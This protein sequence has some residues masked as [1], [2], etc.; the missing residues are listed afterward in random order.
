ME[1]SRARTIGR[2]YLFTH[3]ENASHGFAV[4]PPDAP[5]TLVVFSDFE[6]PFCRRFALVVDS[7]KLV[8]P[9]VRIVERNFPLEDIHHAAFDA[10]RAA[11]CARDVLSYQAVRRLLF[12]RQPLVEGRQ[13]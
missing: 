8:H 13:W 12:S 6:C 1:G 5:V 11:E 10:A 3:P 7:L 4:G 2:T 9:E